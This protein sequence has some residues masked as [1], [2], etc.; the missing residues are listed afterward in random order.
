VDDPDPALE[1]LAGELEL[2]VARFG[3]C[4]KSREALERVLADLYDAQG[5]IETTPAFVV[6]Q[7]NRGTLVTGSRPV[8]QFERLIRGRLEGDGGND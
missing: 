8:D 7:D 4:L 6:L 1:T 2:D 3:A 5:I